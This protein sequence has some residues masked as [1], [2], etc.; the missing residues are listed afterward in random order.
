MENE[1]LNENAEV[2]FIGR[3]VENI[4]E[5]KLSNRIRKFETISSLVNEL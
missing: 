4:S 2:W 5:N 1:V 3:M